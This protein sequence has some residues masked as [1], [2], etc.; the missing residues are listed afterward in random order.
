MGVASNHADLGILGALGRATTHARTQ[1]FSSFLELR[2][3]HES[4]GTSFFN[5]NYNYN[6]QKTVLHIISVINLC[7]YQICHKQ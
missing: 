7:H 3:L 2:P 5:Y 4:S 6:Q 1:K